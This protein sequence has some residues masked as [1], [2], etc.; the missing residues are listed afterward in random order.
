VITSSVVLRQGRGSSPLQ[1]RRA[2]RS[3]AVAA[4]AIIA[5]GLIGCVFPSPWANPNQVSFFFPLTFTVVADSPSYPFSP[6][7][8]EGSNASGLMRLT[9]TIT[10]VSARSVSVSRYSPA[11]ITVF[12]ILYSAD[13]IVSP[14]PIGQTQAEGFFDDDPNGIAHQELITLAPQ[15]RLQLPVLYFRKFDLQP[16]VIPVV[17]RY[18]PPGPGVYVLTFAYAYGGPT[19]GFPNVYQGRLISNPVRVVVQ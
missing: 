18:V 6:D 4:L 5:S 17:T 19:A 11:V 15:E 14:S 8:F 1:P 2:N 7:L 3:G 13:G 10:N 12:D 16:T 9:A